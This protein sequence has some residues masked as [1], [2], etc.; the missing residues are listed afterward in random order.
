MLT[1][2]DFAQ[3]HASDYLD[4]RLGWR[5][6]A[7]VRL[8]LLLCDNCRRFVAQLRQVRA[9]LLRRAAAPR[10]SNEDPVALQA[11]AERLH[12]TRA[13]QKNSDPPL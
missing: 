9:V 11:L 13:A 7:G 12:A 10:V 1:C 4:R 3:R 8:H 5:A 6:R 2:R